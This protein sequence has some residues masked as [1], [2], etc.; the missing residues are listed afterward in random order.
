MAIGYIN[1]QLAAV[2]A[3][4]QG[5]LPVPPPQVDA[6]APPLPNGQVPVDIQSQPVAM[7]SFD[8]LNDGIN[9]VG[10]PGDVDSAIKTAEHD[11]D[12][13]KL[14]RQGKGEALL[15][16]GAQLLSSRTFGEGISKGM[17]AYVQA[18][19]AARTRN[20]PKHEGVADGAYD[21]I[22]DPVDDSVTY[23][24]TPI[25]DYKDNQ[26][27]LVQNNKLAIGQLGYDKT[28]DAASITANGSMDRTIYKTDADT[29]TADKDRDSRERVAR[30]ANASHET[31]ANIMGKW[32]S[33]N[34][35]PNK[36]ELSVMQGAQDAGNELQLYDQID[37]LLDA[38]DTGAGAG[39]V[40]KGTRALASAL[41]TDL[42]GVNVDH[43]QQLTAFVG[44]IKA[45]ASLMKG[46]G[47]ISNYE[48]QIMDSALPSL[49]T[50]PD[51]IR[52]VTS[53][54]RAKAQR[55]AQGLGI[56]PDG[57]TYSLMSVAHGGSSPSP[58]SPPSA[59][60]LKKKYGLK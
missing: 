16:L 60:D 35:P 45:K 34:R 9:S 57:S 11:R 40:A 19:N 55:D 3:A 53:I 4:Q 29:S 17:L 14:Q 13:K 48:R 32:R 37:G 6:Q 44:Q 22:T 42:G 59:E 52:A 33:E 5:K 2:L 50:N 47:Q 56:R 24:R 46:Q 15:A 49:D 28:V 20:T 38:G 41:G 10:R 8:S 58:S 25:A 23:Q 27:K 7:P 30:W 21:K 31:V 18:L 43:M 39:V 26:L 51:S 1:P 54:M 12:L 36:M